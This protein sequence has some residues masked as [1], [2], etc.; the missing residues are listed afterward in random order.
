MNLNI[1]TTIGIIAIAISGISMAEAGQDRNKKEG[2]RANDRAHSRSYE[3]PRHTRHFREK[4]QRKQWKHAN[5][6]RND[7]RKVRHARKHQYNKHRS[8][9]NRGWKYRNR[10]QYKSN[11]HNYRYM[12]H[13]TYVTPRYVSPSYSSHNVV[14][15][16]QHHSNRLLP[17]LAGGLIG[18][19]IAS[20]TSHG[21][22]GAVLG[23]AI[24]GAIVG[25]AIAHH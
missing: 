4:S 12:R 10:Q 25:N 24:F 23:G 1:K 3:K 21:E 6:H 13:T 17:V 18:S 9:W 8:G 7:Y 11:R 20:E 15:S 5:R 2:H 16:S 22:P 19:A 14:V